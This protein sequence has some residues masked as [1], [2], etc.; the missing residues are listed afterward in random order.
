MNV[1]ID[2][3]I[4]NCLYTGVCTDT[5]CFKFSNVSPKTFKIAAFLMEM[6][7][8]THKI[9]KIMFDTKSRSRLKIERFILD[10]IKMYFNDRCAVSYITNKVINES[11]VSEGD[12][13]GVSALTRQ[14]EGV[15]LGVFL[16]EKKD[17]TYK[18]S[19]KSDGIINC[20]KLASYFGGGGH[21][22]AAGCEIS[23]NT[24][25]NAIIKILSA[26]KQE[27]N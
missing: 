25:D 11:N 8:E 5:G 9:N 13:D 22:D 6:G 1:N 18:V 23:E 3:N 20:S 15:I 2:K 27:F 4:A 17:G 19:F 12:I 10:N 16:R 26:I 14:I 24:P 21:K 7:A